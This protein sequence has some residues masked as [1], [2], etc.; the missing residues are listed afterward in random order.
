MI[1]AAEIHGDE[2][3]LPDGLF[4]RD[5]MGQAAV[6]AGHHNGVE[7]HVRGAVV[8]H[9][10]LEPGGDLLFR[11]AGT[12][13]LQNVLQSLLR[14]ALGGHHGLQFFVVLHHPQVPQQVRGGNQVTGQC[15]AVALM[16]LDRHI[17]ILEAH[18]PDA[19]L[20]HDLLYQGSVAPAPADLPQLRPLHI[21][22]RGLR[23]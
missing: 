10:I 4:R 17:G 18:A 8:E 3:S 23:P 2:L 21:A 13:L 11:N 20:R 7:G 22:G 12:D 9:Q 5:A 19:L 16:V 15:L 6:G 1:N 14:D